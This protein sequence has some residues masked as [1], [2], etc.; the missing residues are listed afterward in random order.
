MIHTEN[1]IIIGT[2]PD[3]ERI[4]YRITEVDS[5][6]V[7]AVDIDTGKRYAWDRR[8]YE[9]RNNILFGVED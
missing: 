1:E 8:S 9:K 6:C 2:L 5:D 3:G 4:K 7:Y